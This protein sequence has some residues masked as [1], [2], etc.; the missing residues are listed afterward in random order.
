MMYFFLLFTIIGWSIGQTL[1]KLGYSKATPLD[2]FLIGGLC[3]IVV[4][5]PYVYF[6]PPI[7]KDP[8][9]FFA[10]TS[11]VVLCNI[12]FYYCLAAGEL[13]TVSAILG[14]YP[15]FTVLFAVL[16][17]GEFLTYEQ[18]A[19]VIVI[20][21]GVA[22]L[23]AFSAGNSSESNKTPKIWL[24]FALIS[25]IL[26]GV[27]DALTKIIVDNANA[28]AYIVYYTVFQLFITMLLKFFFGGFKFD[29]GFLKARLSFLGM[30]LM[31]GGG[32][33]FTLAL[34]LGKASIV[35]PFSSSYLAL[36]ALFSWLF[37]NEKMNYGKLS[38]I[39][40]IIAGIMWL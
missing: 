33:F 19:A 8:A 6:N 35:V 5:T 37:L 3:A 38:A 11:F 36:V 39:T 29:F 20:I 24:L 26:V 30:F 23:S 10:L 16:F 2:S 34:S 21:L 25:A 40:M 13:A 7:F 32:L 27:G 31:T 1:L 22:S 9:L 18:W 17:M 12:T 28:S 15:L 4:W 14:S